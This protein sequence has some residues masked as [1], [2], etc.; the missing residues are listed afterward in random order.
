VNTSVL[1]AMLREM[2]E[3]NGERYMAGPFAG[4]SEAEKRRS[5]AN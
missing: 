5:S 1:G 2:Q 3:V 4:R